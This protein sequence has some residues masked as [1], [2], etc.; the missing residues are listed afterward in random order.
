[1]QKE[2]IKK[3]LVIRFRQMGDAILASAM[4]SSLK[5]S[6]PRAEVH[7]VL[8][9]RI[10]P[11]FL[12]HPHIDKVISFSGEVN[13]NILLYIKK[14]WS[15][16]HNEHYDV[17]IDMRSTVRTLFFSLFSLSTPLRIGYRKGYTFLLNRKVSLPKEKMD[18]LEMNRK[19]VNLLS[20]I[21]PITDVRD[22]RLYVT[23]EE[24]M[25]YRK[26]MVECGVNFDHAVIL[27][28][29]T[30]KIL[31]KRW[32]LQFMKEII[33][34]I[35]TQ[36][37]CLQ[38]IFNY[39]PGQ[40]EEVCRRVYNE[41]GCPKNVFIDIRADSVRGL[42][43]L[44]CNCSFYFGNEGGTRHL[45]QALGV[46]SYSIFSPGAAKYKW[47]PQNSIPSFGVDVSDILCDEQRQNMSEEKLF[48]SINPDFVWQQLSTHLES[49]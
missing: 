39:A 13:K 37:K 24:K 31:K 44:C 9:E 1:M 20:D 40:E 16:V 32:N 46:P 30:T 43:A 6:F 38:V 36:Y 33:G 34:R 4:C 18:V 29:V 17:I 23:E 14:V 42:M 8:N 21:S 26:Y 7:I 3:I 47:L 45:I 27:I 15:V 41:L 22:F 5:K 19:F 35:V 25:R 11:I 28:G 12:H 48:N 49:L 10:A 2:D